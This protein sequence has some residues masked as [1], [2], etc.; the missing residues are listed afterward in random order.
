MKLIS[1]LQVLF[2]FLIISSLSSPCFAHKVRIFAW[3]D[4]DNIVT[5]SK[6]SRGKSA[7]NAEITVVETETGKD[8]LSGTTNTDGIFTFPLPKINSKELKIIVDTGDGHKNSWLFNLDDSI[9]E[10]RQTTASLPK[11][12]TSLQPPTPSPTPELQEG[13]H[14]TITASEL[15]RII[16]DSLDK[17]LAPINRTLAE[18]AEKGPS[19][20]D[21]LGGLGYIIGLAGIVAYMQSLKNKK[22]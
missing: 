15:T 1:L 22:E 2:I 12:Q 8:L 10:D 9:P 11:S 17:K 6:F 18:N 19:L 4:G 13:T 5:E 16:E 7:R 14:Q 3:Q 21:I 20:Q